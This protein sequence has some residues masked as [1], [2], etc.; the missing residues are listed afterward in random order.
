MRDTLFRTDLENHAD[1]AEEVIRYYGYDKIGYSLPNTS[2]SIQIGA[3]KF[4][5]R[6]TNQTNIGRFETMQEILTYSFINKIGL[7]SNLD[8]SPI[9]G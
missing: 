4:I 6:P 5:K 1:I 8:K 3:N 2:S 9:I 7:L